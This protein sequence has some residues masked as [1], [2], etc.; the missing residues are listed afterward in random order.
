VSPLVSA[1]LTLL[2]AQAPADTGASSDAL[3]KQEAPPNPWVTGGVSVGIATGIL[4]IGRIAWW[5]HGTRPFHVYHEGFFGAGT[6]AGGTDKLGH[7]GVA[8]FSVDAAAGIYRTLGFDNATATWLAMGFVFAVFNGFEV[9]GDGFTQYGMSPEDLT[10]NT[11][12]IL[13]GG[14]FNFAPGLHDVVGFRLG[15]LPTKDFLAH[16]RSPLKLINDY[17]GMMFY[18][19]L[20]LKGLIE[21]FGGSPGPLR[22][23]MTGVVYETYKYSPILERT[24]TRRNLGVHVSLSFAEILRALGQGDDGVE[25]YAKIFDYYAIPFL[26]VALLRD[27]N[28]N[29]SDRWHLNFGVANRAEVGF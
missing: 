3:S 1:L 24:E 15:Y 9:F 10:M 6:Y 8:Y 4:A 17:S 20:K 25:A 14:I 23:L 22:Y 19:D 16:D 5:D 11:L 26:T 12:G 2:V 7:L 29:E 27:F 21:A 28:Q 18:A 13:I